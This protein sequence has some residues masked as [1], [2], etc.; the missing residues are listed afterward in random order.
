MHVESYLSIRIKREV[1]NDMRYRIISKKTL[2][3]FLVG[4]IGIM[5]CCLLGVRQTTLQVMQ[6]FRSLPIYSVDT[7]EDKISF[8]INCA[9]GNEDI[10]EILDTLDQYQVKATFFLVGDWCERFPDSVKQIADRGHEIGNHSDS[11]A[12]MPS[13]EREE[14]VKELESCSEK[15]EKIIGKKPILF[16][17]P[18]G[19]Y[20]N[21]VVDTARETGYE[22]IQWDCDSLDWKGLSIDQMRERIMKKIQKGSI[23][24]FHND[25]KYTAQALPQIIVDIQEKGYQIVPVSELI[26]KDN[27]D[28]DHA[29][30][31]HENKKQTD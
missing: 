21:M 23:L 5:T 22:V 13:L 16:R 20:N 8:G 2:C 4:V 12:D 24:L 7:P 14:I 3:F 1:V 11:H 25:T 30:R 18:S 19:S 26:Y 6:G 17:P 29:G 10:P 31:Q 9:W 15:I 28:I 27:Y